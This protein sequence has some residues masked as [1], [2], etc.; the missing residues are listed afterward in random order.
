MNLSAPTSQIAEISM[1]RVMRG[2]KCIR[3]ISP[4]SK[5]GKGLVEEKGIEGMCTTEFI[6]SIFRS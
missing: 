6:T 2:K 3:E 5:E 4:D 1:I